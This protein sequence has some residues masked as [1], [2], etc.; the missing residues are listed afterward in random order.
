MPRTGFKKSPG[1]A[2]ELNGELSTHLPGDTLTGDVVMEKPPKEQSPYGSFVRLKL[3]GRVKTKYK[4]K[5]NN[6]TSITRGR[7]V[8]FD[9]SLLL[10]KSELCQNGE[11]AWSFSIAIPK[12]PQPGFAGRGDEFTPKPSGGYLHTRGEDKKEVDVTK[13]H[14]PSVL[15]YFSESAMSGKTVEAYI[16]YVLVATCGTMTAYHP[17][18]IRKPSVQSPITDCKIKTYSDWQPNVVKSLKLLPEHADKILTFGQKSSMFFRPGKTPKYSFTVKVEYPQVIQLEHPKPIPLNIYIVPDLDPQKTT[19]CPDNDIT[20]LPPVQVVSVEIKLKGDFGIRCPGTFWDS[21]TVKNHTFPFSFPMEIKP[22]TIPVLHAAAKTPVL[23]QIISAPEY[24]SEP[25]Q[26]IPETA[27]TASGAT[28][29][30]PLSAPETTSLIS[31]TAT[32]TLDEVNITKPDSN[33]TLSYPTSAPPTSKR[34]T[35]QGAPLSIEPMALNLGAHLS[36]FLGCS[37]ASTCGHRAVSFK[38]Q[39]YPTFATY[40]ISLKYQLE[41]KITLMCAGEKSSISRD[42][43]VIIVAPSEEQESQKTRE[44]GT[45]GMK[46]NYD[47]LEQGFGV[48]MQVIGGIVQAVT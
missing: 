4:K 33:T 23:G 15:Y 5:T 40:N 17:I 29:T 7:A 45:Q 11:H 13:H 16:E 2:I 19:I 43:P 10:S 26:P 22:I 34:T 46:K 12:S 44:L 18:Y 9:Q 14:L 32:V 39:V 21:D 38:R 3:F 28:L 27:S 24:S 30:G 42:N 20:T 36:V 35:S 48:V 6:G 1:L 8:L 41:W 37:A 47:D 31:E 25:P